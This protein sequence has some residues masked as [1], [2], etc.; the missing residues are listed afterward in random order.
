MKRICPECQNKT[1]PVNLLSFKKRVRCEHCNAQFMTTSTSMSM[2]II[3][4]LGSI[5]FSLAITA[6]LLLQSWIIF[7]ILLLIVPSIITM[8]H[9]IFGKLEFVG[10]KAM[11]RSKGI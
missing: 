10:I 4:F 7:I 6:G 5:W 8:L 3:S 1:L 11:L 9:T 2:W